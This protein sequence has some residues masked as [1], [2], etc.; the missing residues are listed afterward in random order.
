MENTTNVIPLIDGIDFNWA[1]T[2]VVFRHIV[3]GKRLAKLVRNADHVHVKLFSFGGLDVVM[4]KGSFQ[5]A[6]ANASSDALYA[7]IFNGIDLTVI[8][9]VDQQA[10]GSQLD[11]IATDY[12]EAGQ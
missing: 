12:E 10:Q 8:G 9:Q 2:P 4:Q 6:I 1:E 3:D 7:A 11:T 5:A